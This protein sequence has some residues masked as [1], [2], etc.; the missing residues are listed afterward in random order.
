MFMPASQSMSHFFAGMGW[1]VVH[2]KL[3]PKQEE[4]IRGHDFFSDNFA[5]FDA[6][7]HGQSVIWS[8]MYGILEWCDSFAEF[9]AFL[10]PSLSLSLS[11]CS[12]PSSLFISPGLQRLCDT[13]KGAKFILHYRPLHA[14]VKSLYTHLVVN[15]FRPDK[16]PWNIDS[17]GRSVWSGQLRSERRGRSGKECSPVD[18]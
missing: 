12:H 15:K 4:L 1:Q 11:C 3:W 18:L 16:R 5:E 6:S 17:C 8:P 9:I 13:Y 14:Y 2:G 10:F 7:R